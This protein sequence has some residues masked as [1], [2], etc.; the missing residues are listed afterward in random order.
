M[1]SSSSSDQIIKYEII[2]KISKYEK[3]NL[4]LRIFPQSSNNDQILF[5]KGGLTFDF[6]GV[7]YGSCDAVWYSI[8]KDPFNNTIYNKPLVA[9]E[10]TDALN[11]GSSGNAQYQRFHHALGA[12]KN[13]IIG[14]YYLKKGKLLIRPDL[15]KMAY[16]ASR[17]EIGKYIIVDDLEKVNG[18]LEALAKK[19][20]SKLDDLI[21]IILNEMNEVWEEYFYKN[22][23]SSMEIFARKRSTIIFDDFVIKHAGRMKRNFTDSS[24]RAG[25]I[26][27]GELYLTKYLFPGKKVIYLFPRMTEQDFRELDNKKIHDKEWRLIRNEENVFVKNIDDIIGVPDKIKNDLNE[28]KQT[29]LKGESMKKYKLIVTEL[30]NML[31]SGKAKLV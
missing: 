27:L 24:Q 6:K 15:Y 16:N 3:E 13:G 30:E 19:E 2:D 14:I 4:Y 18:L 28:M 17:M 5:S 20:S 23:K 21:N 1:S 31:K 11:R 25:H 12:A 9:L 22:Y 7:T 10:G 26:A 29:P 8:E